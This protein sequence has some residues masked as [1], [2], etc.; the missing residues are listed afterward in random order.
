MM[1]VSGICS[2]LY[3]LGN[4]IKKNSQLSI[5]YWL[6]SDFNIVGY[7]TDSTVDV[8]LISVNGTR[9]L[10]S[11]A[12]RGKILVFCFSISTSYQNHYVCMVWVC[13]IQLLT[14]LKI[15]FTLKIYFRQL[16]LICSYVCILCKWNAMPESLFLQ[17]EVQYVWA[18]FI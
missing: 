18:Y 5:S 2:W 6:F 14:A 10:K 7:S 4:Y 17:A 11:S 16:K 13:T 9:F 8:G 3:S 15:T 12:R 1:D